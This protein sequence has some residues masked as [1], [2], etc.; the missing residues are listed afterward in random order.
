M[1]NGDLLKLKIKQHNLLAWKVF[2]NVTALKRKK[3]KHSSEQSCLEVLFGRLRCNE[4]L[5]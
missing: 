5:D 4:R 3:H 1:L 2:G